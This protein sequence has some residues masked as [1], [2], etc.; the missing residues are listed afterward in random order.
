MVLGQAFCRH[1]VRERDADADRDRGRPVLAALAAFDDPW[2]VG[3]LH[4]SGDVGCSH[5]ASCSSAKLAADDGSCRPLLP[6]GS[7]VTAVSFRSPRST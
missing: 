4:D 5:A 1:L 3:A 7:K 6:P 2:P